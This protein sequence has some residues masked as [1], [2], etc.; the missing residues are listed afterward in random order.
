MPGRA[1]K[2][3]RALHDLG[4]HAAAERLVPA[5]ARDDRRALERHAL[6]QKHGVADQ[7]AARRHEPVLVDLAQHRADDDGAR[8][9]GRDFRVPAHERDADNRARLRHLGEE[10]FHLRLVAPALGQEHRRHEPARLGAAHGE[11]VGVDV[12]RVPAHLVGGKG[13]GIGRGDEIAVAHVEHGGILAHLR[14]HDHAR[15]G[16]H[17]FGEQSLEQLGGELAHGEKRHGLRS[18]GAAGDEGQGAASVA[19]DTALWQAPSSSAS[20]T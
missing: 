8:Q 11:V 12:Q 17:V 20:R 7:R 18:I 4:G 13:D 16:R 14:S 3:A 15:V 5:L 2:A 19:Y 1:E 6:R 9:P 10:L